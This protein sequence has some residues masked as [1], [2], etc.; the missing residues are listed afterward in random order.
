LE[1]GDNFRAQHSPKPDFIFGAIAVTVR[2]TPFEI[3]AWSIG[4][5]FCQHKVV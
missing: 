5:L 2:H 3:Q 4:P 1:H